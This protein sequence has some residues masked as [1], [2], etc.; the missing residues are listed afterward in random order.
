[1]TVNLVVDLKGRAPV[2]EQ[3]RT[4]LAGYIRTGALGPGDKLPTVRGLAADLGIAVNTVARA[5]TELEAGGLVE[6]RRRA[7]TVVK[8]IGGPA[9]PADVVTAADRLADAAQA[10]RLTDELTLDVLRAAL[11]RLG[12]GPTV[13]PTTGVA[14]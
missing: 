9:I 14:R 10:A 13:E 8:A 1:M 12:P 3:I 11:R 4:Q 5:Y 7:G 6:T 2:Y